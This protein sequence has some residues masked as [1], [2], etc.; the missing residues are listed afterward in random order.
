MPLRATD[1]RGQEGP[2]PGW[3][4]DSVLHALRIRRRRF[5]DSRRDARL[6][7]EIDAE[8]NG[9]L[10][11]LEDISVGGARVSLQAAAAPVVGDAVRLVFTLASC[12]HSLDG[13]VRHASNDGLLVH[14]GII[15]TE[16]Q[17][18]AIELLASSI[19]GLEGAQAS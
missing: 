19:G 2:I 4:V 9:V 18:E 7:V 8:L 5:L 10:C 6:R 13:A 3:S 15:F 17:V 1:F 11:R 12:G 14:L 16:D